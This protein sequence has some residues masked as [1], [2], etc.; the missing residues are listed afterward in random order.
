MHAVVLWLAA[1][2]IL[3]ATPACAADEYDLKCQLIV[4]HAQSAAR[5]FNEGK[6]DEAEKQVALVYAAYQEA[7]TLQPNEAQAYANFATFALNTHRC[8][9]AVLVRLDFA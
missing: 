9:L 1:A 2:G 6:K 5:A 4:Q 3:A 8:A 7:I